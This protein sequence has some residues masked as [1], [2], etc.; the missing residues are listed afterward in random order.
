MTLSNPLI[1]DEV[2]PI[3]FGN[4]TANDYPKSLIKKLF[5]AQIKDMHNLTV[6]MY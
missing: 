2:K 6:A 3:V 5:Y 1:L 4:L